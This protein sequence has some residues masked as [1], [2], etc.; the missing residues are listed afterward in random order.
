MKNKIIAFLKGEGFKFLVKKLVGSAAFAGPKA[1]LIKFIYDYLFDEFAEPLMK[2]GF[3]RMGYAYDV[4][5]GKILL[6][7][8]NDA[9][10]DDWRDIVNRV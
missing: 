6:K 4:Q 2:Y 10:G 5:R 3:R 8:V 9:T 7:K 1:W